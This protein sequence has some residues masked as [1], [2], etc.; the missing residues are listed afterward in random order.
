MQVIEKALVFFEKAI[1]MQPSQAK[2]HMLAAGCHRR[3]GNLHRAVTMYQSI[4][5]QFPEDE[6][7]L[8]F[9]IQLCSELGMRETQDYIAELKK[10]E[11]TKEVRD[12]VSSSRPGELVQL[13]YFKLL[14]QDKKFTK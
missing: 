9:L 14:K 8:R 11:K 10:M 2:W 7:C 1:T 13:F 4:H 5:Q 12:R 3:T 6:E